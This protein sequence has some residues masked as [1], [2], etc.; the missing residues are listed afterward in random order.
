MGRSMNQKNDQR[1]VD[2]TEYYRRV[3][4]RNQSRRNGIREQWK[5]ID[6]KD[7]RRFIWFMV[8]CATVVVVA[9]VRW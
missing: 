5:E 4:E 7:M 2:W 1:V 3:Q 9:G 8:G 6:W